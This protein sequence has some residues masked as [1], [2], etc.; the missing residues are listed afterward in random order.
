MPGR[1]TDKTIFRVALP[2]FLFLFL[3]FLPKARSAAPP[4][5]SPGLV[6]NPAGGQKGHAE[7]GAPQ[8][9]ELN[10]LINEAMAKNPQ[11][12]AYGFLVSAQR[13][14]VPQVKSLPDPMVAVGYQ[15][16]GWDRYS[17]GD[18]IMSQWMFSASQTFPYP[19][20]LGLKGQ[21]AGKEAQYAG[22]SYEDLRLK[23]ARQVKDLYFDLL[24]YYKDL[25]IIRQRAGLYTQ[26]EKAALARYSAGLAPQEE[27]ILAQTEKYTLLEKKEKIEQKITATDA[28]LDS[29]LGRPA[30]SPLGRPAE[31]GYMLDASSAAPLVGA[32]ISGSPRIKAQ[33]KLVEGARAGVALARKQY[34]PD[35][36]VTGGVDKKGGPY[37]DDWSLVTAVNVPLYYRTKQREGVLEAQ[38][39]LR[40][41]K[42]DLEAGKLS[43]A[44]DVEG[45][46][47]VAQSAGNLMD[48]YRKGLI[49]KTYQD[50]EAALS[51]YVA[52]N[53]TALTAINRLKSLLDYEFAYWQQYTG[54]QKAIAGIEALTGKTAYITEGP[55]MRGGQH[56]R[57]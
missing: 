44:S 31:T 30:G 21:I 2:V 6:Q 54:R 46:F 33:Q 50:F 7:A 14:R 22:E 52:G 25:D 12:A 20:K 39:L 48:L 26:L 53:V 3:S 47:S 18:T 27:V 49:P 35:F 45:F 10:D 8:P 24:L 43:I 23:I 38:A 16:E 5:Q 15:N 19:G 36:T 29:V 34:Y 40:K 17:Y 32:A 11:L 57:K 13:H 37:K 1:G 56:A 41:A 28:G 51:G 42:A 55:A 9:L 4:G